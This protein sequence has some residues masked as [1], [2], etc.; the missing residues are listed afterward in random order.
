MLSP[1][2]KPNFAAIG[3]ERNGE[4]RVGPIWQGP[5]TSED[6]PSPPPPGAGPTPRLRLESP[7]RPPGKAAG[8]VEEI[9]SVSGG[10]LGGSPA[11][12]LLSSEK[13]LAPARPQE[14]FRWAGRARQRHAEPRSC[15]YPEE[16]SVCSA[17]AEGGLRGSFFQAAAARAWPSDPRGSQ[18]PARLHPILT[19][20]P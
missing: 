17:R 15:S 9:L 2:S 10:V 16:R 13:G 8:Q 18:P 14:H 6:A 3:S 4:G 19:H 11:S 1:D 7:S 12:P 20:P 5:E